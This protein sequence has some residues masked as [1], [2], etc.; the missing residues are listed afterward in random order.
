MAASV[1]GIQIASTAAADNA[2]QYFTVVQI[3]GIDRS[4]SYEMVESAKVTPRRNELMVQY[5]KAAIEWRKNKDGVRP[6]MPS[7]NP[8]RQVSSKDEAEKLL[9]DLKAKHSIVL[10]RDIEGKASYEAVQNIALQ[11]RID[12]LDAEYTNAL[13][14]YETQKK[15]HAKDS[16]G[17]VFAGKKPHKP[18]VNVVKRDVKDKATAEA[19]VA[20]LTPKSK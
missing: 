1:L 17:T 15:E 3:L 12:D 11:K 7:L 6:S 14:E 9:V 5:Q 2:P 10:I 16:P 18:S 4:M 20:K 8:I 19:A 13:A